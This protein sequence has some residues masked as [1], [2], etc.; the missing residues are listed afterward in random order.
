VLLFD[1]DEHT[2]GFGGAKAC[3]DHADIPVGPDRPTPSP[4]PI[5]PVQSDAGQGEAR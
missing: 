5:I 3:F 2:G 1:V 4:R